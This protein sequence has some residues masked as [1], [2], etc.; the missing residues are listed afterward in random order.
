M[1]DRIDLTRGPPSIS[2]ALVEYLEAVYPD[3]FP[4]VT[5][6]GA[7]AIALDLMRQRGAREVVAFLRHHLDAQSRPTSPRPTS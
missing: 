7:E 6:A 4:T 2:L 1:S 3:R 5:G